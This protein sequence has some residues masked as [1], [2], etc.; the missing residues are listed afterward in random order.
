MQDVTV[1][2]ST[3]KHAGEA[4]MSLSCEVCNMWHECGGQGRSTTCGHVHGGDQGIHGVQLRGADWL[5]Q[6]VEAA[7]LGAAH[8]LAVRQL[9]RS[10]QR[11]AC[12]FPSVLLINLVACCTEQ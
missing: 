10:R 11:L 1:S 3:A 5:R 4:G 9:R 12:A 2:G 8:M 7:K 6:R